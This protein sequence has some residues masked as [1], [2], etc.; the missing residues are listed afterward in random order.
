MKKKKIKLWIAVSL[1]VSG[2][3]LFA[4]LMTAL[5]WDFSRLSTVR[6]ESVTHDIEQPFYS[7]SIDTKMADITFLP[8]EDGVGRVVAD[9]TEKLKYSVS[10]EDGTLKI[11]LVDEREWH[12][13]IGLF[14]VTPKLTV[15]LPQKEYEALT[16]QASTGD[17]QI[18]GDFTFAR[19][20]VEISTGDVTLGADVNGQTRVKTSTGDILVENMTTGALD[21]RATTGD[22]TVKNVNCV[23]NMDLSATTGRVSVMGI[24][25]VG[26][27][28]VS[29][30]TGEAE[31]S[32]VRCKK[33]T[34]VGTTGDLCMKNVTAN[35]SFSI[36]R[37][38][39]DVTFDACDAAEITVR[40][41]T[42]DVKGSLLSSKM[43]AVSATTGDVDVPPSSGDGKCEITTS[44]GD[45]QIEIVSIQPD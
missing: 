30:G 6:Y 35:E 10:V 26:N 29:I 16:I 17:V 37:T 39:G 28:D 34:T 21:L 32:D 3:L 19:L 11:G 4:G 5:G 22:I 42:G 36:E 41:T 44:T 14:F 38:A 2:L 1:V 25:C 31:L 40:T 13:R 7:I 45:I 27:I 12:D 15:Y 43:F 18:P 33:L 9:E 8:A 20:T 23:R 24:W